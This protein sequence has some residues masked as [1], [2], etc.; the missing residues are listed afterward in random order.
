MRETFLIKIV[1]S[2]SL[3]VTIVC[4]NYDDQNRFEF[5]VYVLNTRNFLRYASDG[6]FDAA[7]LFSSSVQG[8]PYPG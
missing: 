4:I 6:E 3:K 2:F 1:A 7:L 8:Q 5:S